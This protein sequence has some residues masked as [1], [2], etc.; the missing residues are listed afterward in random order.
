[1]GLSKYPVFCSKFMISS[2]LL[3]VSGWYLT[4]LCLSMRASL[5]IPIFLLLIRQI[6]AKNLLIKN[7]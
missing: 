5:M 6:L 2:T 3:G 1:M 4:A 7:I